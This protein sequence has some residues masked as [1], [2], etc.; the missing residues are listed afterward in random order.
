[1]GCCSH[2]GPWIEGPVRGPEDGLDS[3]RRSVVAHPAVVNY[4][5]GV[6]PADLSDFIMSTAA[7]AAERVRGI[8]ADQYGGEI[9]KFETKTVDELTRD[10]LEEVADV[11]A[12]ASM[13]AIKAASLN[14]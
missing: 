7:L 14:R 13:I 6:D 12:Y 4:G 11:I 2:N 10:I 1:M 8:G 5:S 9:Q 3:G